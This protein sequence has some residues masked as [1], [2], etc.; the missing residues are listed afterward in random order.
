MERIDPETV[1]V[2]VVPGDT[3]GAVVVIVTI[4]DS[5]GRGRSSGGLAGRPMWTKPL[6]FSFGASPSAS[7]TR[8]S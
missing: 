3:R 8:R 7:S 4:A 2:P 6:I 1:A 5:G